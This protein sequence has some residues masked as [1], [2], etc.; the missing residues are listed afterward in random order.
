MA[1]VL[2]LD[3]GTA[4]IGYSLRD[5]DKGTN[6]TE[7]LVRFGSIIF[8]KGVGNSKTG[9]FSYAAERTKHRASRRLYQARR[10]R[11]WETLATLI[12]FGFCP[13]SIEDLDR[14]R[15]YDKARNLKRRYPVDA[16]NFEQ[17]VRLDF[18]GDGKSDYSSPY[19]L[20]EELAIVQLDFSQEINRFKLGRALYHIAQR[21]G[22]KSSKGETLKE[23]EDAVK[24][25]IANEMSLES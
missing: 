2:G 20:R 23:Q 5:T 4:S 3:L 25:D 18:D 16:A 1:R 22:F 17:W 15:V 14:W 24:D 19:Q 8:Q 10:Y 6:I 11:I 7:Q 9:E 21:R 12:E 13:L